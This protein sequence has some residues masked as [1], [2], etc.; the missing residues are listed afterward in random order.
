VKTD[1]LRSCAISF[2][3]AALAIWCATEN[4]PVGA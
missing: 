1:A 2:V 3:W 4:I